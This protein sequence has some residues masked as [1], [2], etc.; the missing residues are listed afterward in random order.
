MAQML[1]A[2]IGVGGMDNPNP[3]ASYHGISALGRPP[4]LGAARMSARLPVDDFEEDDEL[5]S[6][7]RIPEE[8]FDQFRASIR[9]TPR[10]IVSSFSIP[11]LASF[12]AIRPTIPPQTRASRSYA[13]NGHQ[14]GAGATAATALEIDDDSDEECLDGN[15]RNRNN[16]NAN[17]SGNN[18]G[19]NRVNPTIASQLSSL[20]NIL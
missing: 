10:A 16:A 7:M 11:Q 9:S 3:R 14:T 18:G 12:R 15:N 6:L 17:N 20:R 4:S 2:N 13:R 8:G 5:E 1:F 19:N